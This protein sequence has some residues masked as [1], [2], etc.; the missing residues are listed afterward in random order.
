VKHLLGA[1]A[2]LLAACGNQVDT[3]DTGPKDAAP[4]DACGG[5]SGAVEDAATDGGFDAGNDSGTDAGD[6]GGDAGADAG[7]AGADGGGDVGPSYH[8]GLFS[9][10]PGWN[11]ESGF[12][13]VVI[14]DQQDGLD[15]PVAVSFAGGAFGGLLYVVNQ[16]DNTV[17]TVDVLTGTV[18]PFTTAWPDPPSLLTTITWDEQRVF[19]GLL[20]VGDQG[21]DS[22]GDST[23]YRVTS[24][25]TASVFAN[26]PGPGLDDIYALAFIGTSTSY[27]SGLYVSGDTD[28]A[29][30][31]WGRFSADGSSVPFSEIAGIEGAEFDDSGLYGGLLIAARPLGGGYAGDGTITPILPNGEAAVPIASNLGGIHAVV[32]SPG[33]A[34]GNTLYAASWDAGTLIRVAPG[35]VVST[36]ASGLQLTNYDGNILDF[37]SDGNVLFVADRL[38]N[39]IVCIEPVP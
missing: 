35:G 34:F 13:A 1:C 38:A 25:G 19:D 15:Q 26:G 20:Y 17:R 7:D 14:A 21:A 5:D 3:P 18:A 2:L 6:A 32:R 27:E 10:D 12:R 37:S 9:E 22:D 33:G 39:R 31:D 16:G 28:G 23:I 8:C 4:I 29:G 11:I 30:V 36:V 24:T